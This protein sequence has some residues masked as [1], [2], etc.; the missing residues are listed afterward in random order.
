MPVRSSKLYEFVVSKK[1]AIGE[2]ILP[3]R[4]FII[5]DMTSRGHEGGD[6]CNTRGNQL[7]SVSHDGCPNA[8]AHDAPFSHQDLSSSAVR[9]W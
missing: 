7:Q 4:V 8:S 2:E 5:H 3:R 1:M 9:I 6:K